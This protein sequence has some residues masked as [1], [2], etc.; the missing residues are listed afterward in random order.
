[1]SITENK[2][3]QIKSAYHSQ[4]IEQ[5]QVSQFN[6]DSK[7]SKSM[8]EHADRDKRIGDREFNNAV[9]Y[10]SENDDINAG[11]CFTS[12]AKSRHESTEK[13][14]KSALVALGNGYVTSQGTV[15]V[16]TKCVQNTQ[17]GTL[18]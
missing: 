8:K 15:I 3:H 17:K 2:M 9:K 14:L 10:M 6:F 5:E 1:M 12:S 7:Q 13:V 11:D 4:S 18:K 16:K